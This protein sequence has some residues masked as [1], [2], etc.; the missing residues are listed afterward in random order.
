MVPVDPAEHLR[1]DF[2]ARLRAITES[3]QEELEG[4]ELSAMRN[5][6][7]WVRPVAAAVVGVTAGTVLVV[8]QVR[9][10]HRQRLTAG[11]A[12][13]RRGIGARR[14]RE[15]AGGVQR[16]LPAGAV[17]GVGAEVR[18]LTAGLPVSRG[19]LRVRGD[20]NDR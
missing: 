5:P 12:T 8:I 18:K 13:K 6:R 11:E 4:W 10:N 20:A 17:A 15:L 16:L 3:A 19:S 9:A 2:S 14:V 1:G 7:N